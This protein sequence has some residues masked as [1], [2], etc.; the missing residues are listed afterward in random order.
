MTEKEKA[1]M[2][3]V[4]F[5][6]K[7]KETKEIGKI[8]RKEIVKALNK[9]GYEVAK[10]DFDVKTSGC[11]TPFQL[12]F[13]PTN[14][15]YNFNNFVDTWKENDLSFRKTIKDCEKQANLDE[16]T[17]TLKEFEKHIKSFCK[18]NGKYHEPEE[19]ESELEM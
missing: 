3:D 15:N 8:L 16:N 10:E 14:K 5:E 19:K 4:S 17:T 2:D 1:K 13:V 18:E 7:K 9:K 11:K 12:F 6:G